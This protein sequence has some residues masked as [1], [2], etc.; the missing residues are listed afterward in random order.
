[1][2]YSYDVRGNRI[3]EEQIISDEITKK[4]FFRYD[5]AGR[6]VE[7]REKIAGWSG[8]DFISSVQTAVTTYQRDGNGNVIEICTPEGYQILRK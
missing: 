2:K 1:M 7:K 8:E 4:V 3:S 5:K 6:L